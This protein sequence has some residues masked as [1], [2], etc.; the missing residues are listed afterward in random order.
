MTVTNHRL[1]LNVQS[2]ADK[3][4]YRK[5]GQNVRDINPKGLGS[6]PQICG[7]KGS[8]GV[9]GRVSENIIAY[10]GQKVCWKVI[11][12]KKRKREKTAKNVGVTGKQ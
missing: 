8:Q 1:P 5:S 2:K 4:V 3:L 10:F 9:R 7:W 6:R 11:Y 12:F